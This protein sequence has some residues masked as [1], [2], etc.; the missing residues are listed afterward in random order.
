MAG[1]SGIDLFWIYLSLLVVTLAFTGLRVYVRAFMARAM[2]ADDWVLVLA[3]VMFATTLSISIRGATAGAFDQAQGK[4]SAARY[5]T[6]LKSAYCCEVLYPPVSLAIRVSVCLFL[7]KIVNNKL[8]RHILYTLLVLVSGASLGYLVVT[9][10]QCVPPSHFWNQI[11][12]PGM[13][14][15]LD[16]RTLAIAGFVH[17]AVSASSACVV[18]VLPVFVLWR[19]RVNMRTK[20]TVIALLGMSIFACV[21]LI[22]RTTTLNKDKMPSPKFF[23]SIMNTA[24]WSMIEPTV[25]IVAASLPTLRPLFKKLSRSGSGANRA[26][27]PGPG[28]ISNRPRTQEMKPRRVELTMHD[29][30]DLETGKAQATMKHSASTM[31][32]D[33]T[34]WST[35]VGRCDVL[36]L[37]PPI[38]ISVHTS[39]EVTTSS[40]DS[41]GAGTWC[42]FGLDV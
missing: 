19:I 20:V 25:G 35:C 9:I 31:S 34:L 27:T 38:G 10:F 23:H 36:E 8:H 17:G 12:E 37:P 26:P 22:V 40:R 3:T 30:R 1:I 11:T 7:L 16:Q 2:S 21:A 32:R 42:L 39:I 4:M 28:R 18:G 29:A 41:G 15:C 13:G 24:L 5:I 14:Y 33:A 6:Y